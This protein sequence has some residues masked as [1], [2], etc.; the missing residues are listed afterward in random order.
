VNYH[1][2]IHRLPENGLAEA[3][4]RAPSNAAARQSLISNALTHVALGLVLTFHLW[5]LVP[6]CGEV[7][8]GF[9]TILPDASQR[10]IEMA[11]KLRTFGM[12][13]IPVQLLGLW[14]D[15]MVFRLSWTQHSQRAAVLYSRGVSGMLLA[16]LVYAGYGAALMVKM[17]I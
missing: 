3:L 7:L 10:T 2:I 9:S 5:I 15:A 1:A 4:D 13:F 8:G 6:I 16:M 11:G 17:G 12:W 14:A